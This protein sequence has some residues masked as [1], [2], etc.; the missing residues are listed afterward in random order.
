M[1]A[2]IGARPVDQHEAVTAIAHTLNKARAPIVGGLAGDVDAIRAAY[3]LALRI[4]A[5]LDADGSDSLYAD[6]SV[7]A[8][9]GAMM[10][11]WAEARARSDL[12]LAVGA[13]AAR[14]PLLAEILERSPSRA[15]VSRRRVVSIGAPVGVGDEHNI[16]VETDRLPAMLGLLRAVIADRLPLAGE[17]AILAEAVGQIR[18]AAF[19]VAVYDPG[20]LGELAIDMLQGLVKD[21]NEKTRFSSL[22]LGVAAASRAALAV[23]TWT[24]GDPPRTGFGRFYPEHDPWRFDASRLI[25]SGEAD[26]TLWIAASKAALPERRVATAALLGS[27]DGGEADIVVEVSVPGSGSPGSI[28]DERR[29]TFA[30]AEAGE[31]DARPSAAAILDAVRSAIDHE[32]SRP[33]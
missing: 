32:G 13:R 24:T 25:A 30:H 28:F 15:G 26:A 17:A 10:T 33:C 9:R 22:A 23:G 1:R 21:L 14:A 27:A 12:V 2:W 3:R 6:L 4:G 19:G 8:S 7:L 11:T 31:P 16:A 5:S 29:G 18:Q 20:E